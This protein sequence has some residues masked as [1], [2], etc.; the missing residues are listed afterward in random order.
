MAEAR[1][2][3]QQ[4]ERRYIPISDFDL[5]KWE[6]LTIG[7]QWMNYLSHQLMYKISRCGT[8]DKET[9]LVTEF[10]KKMLSLGNS[11]VFFKVIL[12][13]EFIEG[14]VQ[15]ISRF[16][17]LELQQFLISHLLPFLQTQKLELGAYNSPEINDRVNAIANVISYFVKPEN[18]KIHTALLKQAESVG[19]NLELKRAIILVCCR[20][21]KTKE[22][23]FKELLTKWGSDITIKHSPVLV[24][25]AQT[26]LLILF[27]PHL[28]TCYL[29]S[30][31]NDANVYLRG[32][33][34][35][36]ESFS[37]G[38]RLYGMVIGE[39]ISEKAERI[40]KPLNFDIDS[41]SQQNEEYN[42]L[43]SELLHLNDRYQL[44]PIGEALS[45]LDT[46]PIDLKE[47]QNLS[48]SGEENSEGEDSDSQRG[49]YP[50]IV[51][52]SETN[53][54]LDLEKLKNISLIYNN[55]DS[56]DD[57][58]FEPYAFPENDDV[59]SD[60]DDDP[61]I[62]K[63]KLI[64]APVYIPS[65]IEYLNDTESYEKQK[66]ALESAPAL[67][68]RKALFGQELLFYAKS[69]GACLAMLK[70]PFEIENFQVLRLR[71]LIA[72][73]S[74]CPKIAPE[75]FAE[76]IVTG[77]LTLQDRMTLL[78]AISL[79]A[80]ALSGENDDVSAQPKVEFASKKLPEQLH[81]LLVT[82][83]DVY[84]KNSNEVDIITKQLQRRLLKD[85]VEDAKDHE[86]LSGPRIL[87]MSSKLQKARDG[88]VNLQTRYTKNEYAKLAGRNFFFPLTGRW[89]SIGGRKAFAQYS[90][91]FQ[92]HY[93][94]TLAILLHA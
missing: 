34:N 35:H 9:P 46:L 28:T 37:A 33:S 24:Q 2:A 52:I 90:E 91:M 39:I 62:T 65:M 3:F 67:I 88:K 94:K 63:K 85:T 49:S 84:T 80:R 15:L 10:F 11:A 76:L 87:R 83:S 70:D 59:D 13:E 72:L 31:S 79:G 19:I 60:D 8:I 86:I 50:K 32:I 93:V 53:D 12:K 40:V 4:M 17:T 57:E 68:I 16:S 74:S 18:M 77:D 22:D 92:A 89:W 71:A 82:D 5:E 36:L 7:E 42:R 43:K 48:N 75:Y 64:T 54:D 45:I 20:N 21:D 55:D 29:T 41:K 81:A 14:L 27:I 66:V 25:E 44:I 23:L 73:V 78:S 47:N 58:E 61:S 26:Q 30:I 56:D 38:P 1:L 51:E 6:W 69:L